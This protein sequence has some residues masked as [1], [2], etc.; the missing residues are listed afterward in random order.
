MRVRAVAAALAVWCVSE[1]AMAAGYTETWNPPEASG[2]VV[3][4]HVTK[5]VRQKP[6]GAKGKVAEAKAGG[7]RGGAHGKQVASVRHGA[8]H[9]AA[10]GGVHSSKLAAHG[11]GAKKVAASGAAKGGMKLA[12][13]GRGRAHAGVSAQAVKQ[14]TQPHEQP[15][16]QLARAK[17]TQGKV[18]HADFA[19]GHTVRP[20]VAKVAAKPV[21]AS[22]NPVAPAVQTAPAASVN[23]GDIA[24]MGTAPNPATA[25]SGALPPI[26]H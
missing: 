19:P 24:P 3:S 20:H 4:G 23:V 8:A 13:L 21:A 17:S 11:A 2:H 26:I 1:A 10:G 22:T 9:G 18:M 25:R 14:R 6:G 16:A 7:K 5:A 15:H 12:A